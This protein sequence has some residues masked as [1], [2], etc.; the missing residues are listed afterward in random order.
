MQ[1]FEALRGRLAGADRLAL[2]RVKDAACRRPEYRSA[3]TSL[4]VY[5]AVAGGGV[6]TVAQFDAWLRTRRGAPA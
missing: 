4:D 1:A 5:E 6:R 2:L 3:V